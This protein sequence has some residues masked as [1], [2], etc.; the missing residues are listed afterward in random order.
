MTNIVNS[1]S[2]ATIVRLRY[3]SM[4]SNPLEF[5]YATGKIGL[6]SVIEE[7][8]GI[9]AGSLPALRPLLALPFLNGGRSAT[10]AF[11][12]NRSNDKKFSKPRSGRYRMADVDLDKLQS[13][14]DNDGK[15]ED[16]DS[17]KHILRQTRVNVSNEKNPH[18]QEGDWEKSQV[19]GWQK[20]DF[21]GRSEA[22]PAS[23]S[24]PFPRRLDNMV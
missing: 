17:Q 23:R 15:D 14:G 12:S 6:W 16:A 3:L 7:G 22:S 5:M 19:L 20:S 2:C 11:G 24:E 1:A 9:F 18:D 10:P 13:M 8:T 4:Y 21:R